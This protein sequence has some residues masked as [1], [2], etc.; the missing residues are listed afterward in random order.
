MIDELRAQARR[1]FTCRRGHS[2]Q[3]APTIWL[4]D[5]P[6]PQLYESPIPLCRRCLNA[7]LKTVETV[8]HE[9]P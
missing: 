5:G 6:D 8:P 4:Y 7:L 1:W 3:G 9:K 2:Q